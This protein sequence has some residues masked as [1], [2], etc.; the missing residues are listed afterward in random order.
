MHG[1]RLL[2][3]GRGKHKRLNDKQKYSPKDGFVKRR[4]ADQATPGK[5]Q[6]LPLGKPRGYPPAF[7]PVPLRPP[8]DLE[9]HLP[10]ASPRARK[11][12][13]PLEY[14][15]APNKSG[16]ED[17]K[18]RRA[19]PTDDERSLLHDKVNVARPN[20]RLHASRDTQRWDG[21]RSESGV[22]SCQ[23]S[24]V[25]VRVDSSGRVIQVLRGPSG[26]WQIKWQ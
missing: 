11:R 25:I 24:V 2:D 13:Q 22:E 6:G 3:V 1:S 14:L 23:W 4:S 26:S 19:D 17:C 7:A 21:R 9:A 5:A 15:C 20:G 8:L 18:Q 16:K 10:P 12:P